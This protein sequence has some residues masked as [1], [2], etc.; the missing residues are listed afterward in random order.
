MHWGVHWWHYASYVP[1]TVS[2]SALVFARF[3]SWC[4]GSVKVAIT[5]SGAVLILAALGMHIETK[6]RGDHH[7]PWYEAARWASCNLDRNAVVGMTDCGLFGSFCD[8]RTVNLDGV[9]NGYEYQAA[10]GTGRLSGYLEAC[11]VTH[12][13]D[14]EARYRN[15]A[16][17]IALP[18]RLHRAP[19]CAIVAS[20][21]A[22]VYISEPAEHILSGSGIR[23]A[24]WRLDQLQIIDDAASL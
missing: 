1:M 2:L 20:R 10:L 16:Y 17:V 19:G 3:H 4:A 11:G 13:A 7:R 6:L 12:I 24:I 9:I 14:Y 15:G 23:F 8:R 5:A 22:E 21:S 18:A